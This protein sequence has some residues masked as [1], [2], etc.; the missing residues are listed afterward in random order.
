MARQRGL[1]LPPSKKHAH[2][3][4]GGFMSSFAENGLTKVD[5]AA[6]RMA[7]GHV[8]ASVNIR[9]GIRDGMGEASTNI[10]NGMIAVGVCGVVSSGMIA[11]GGCV[12]V[13]SL[14]GRGP[15]K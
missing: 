8:D 10:R 6:E 9:D 3:K 15:G 12:V 7:K 11:A 13:S 5:S 2:H 1:D 14:L 4:G